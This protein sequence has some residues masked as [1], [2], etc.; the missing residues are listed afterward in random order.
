MEAA[1]LTVIL[2]DSAVRDLE[3]IDE[4]WASRD[5]PER[6]HQYVRDLIR[7]AE[8]TLADL[9]RAKLGRA[10]KNG[11]LPGTREIPA[12]GIYRVI[13]RLEEISRTALVLRYWHGHRDPSDWKLQE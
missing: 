3:A 12:C 8:F 6:G 5:E 7:V 9:Q 13:Y 1:P 10:I 4:Y 11:V 2:T